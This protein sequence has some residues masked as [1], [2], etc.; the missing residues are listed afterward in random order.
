MRTQKVQIKRRKAWRRIP[1]GGLAEA[2]RTKSVPKAFR[3]VRFRKASGNFRIIA[4]TGRVEFDP[5][6]LGIAELPYWQNS[7]WLFHEYQ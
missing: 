3:G 7:E 6:Y 5:S 4:A 1:S 2:N